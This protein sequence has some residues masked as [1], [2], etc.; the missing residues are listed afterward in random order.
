MRRANVFHIV[1]AP[2]W[3]TAL[4][5]GSYTP[6]SLET[7]GFVHLSELH[8]V[9]DVANAW[10]GTAGDLVVVEFDPDRLDGE[11]VDED[12]YGAAQT[13]P[14]FYSAIPTSAAVAVHPLPRDGAGQFTFQP[15]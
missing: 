4:S 5:S 10:Y 2:D 15:S 7:Q 11:I 8:Q 13:F 6:E 12:L 9:S 14:H 3:D 1:A